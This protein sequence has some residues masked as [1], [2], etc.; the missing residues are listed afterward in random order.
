M[1]GD[2]AED[3]PMAGAVHA[4]AETAG[5]LTSLDAE[6]PFRPP[7]WPDERCDWPPR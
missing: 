4:V 2:V 6:A 1:A 7:A 3:A 5:E